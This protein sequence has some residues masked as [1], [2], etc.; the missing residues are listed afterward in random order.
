MFDELSEL[1]LKT[2]HAK[3]GAKPRSKWDR[4]M[5]TTSDGFSCGHCHAFVS[6]TTILSGVINRNHCPYCL[7][8][9]HL[10]LFKAGDR[11]SA[12]KGKMK[13]VALTLKKSYKKYGE[14]RGEMMLVHLCAECGKIS[15]NR[16]AADDI[17]EAIF[18]LFEGSLVMDLRT[19]SKLE[20]DDIRA[21][22]IKEIGLVK[23]RLFGL[24]E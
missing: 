9:R 6:C 11:L 1:Q 5:Q 16:I 13:P 17:A 15:I 20:K 14:G 8:S 18:E 21:L 2:T 22:G 4:L 3:R 10:D 19:L 12:C 23:R 7:W 24:Q